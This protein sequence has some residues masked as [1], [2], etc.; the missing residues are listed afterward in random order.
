MDYKKVLNILLR[1]TI[2]IYIVARMFNMYPDTNVISFISLVITLSGMIL[3]DYLTY[4][5]INVP[6]GVTNSSVELL[7]VLNMIFLSYFYAKLC[8]LY[9]LFKN[10]KLWQKHLIFLSITLLVFPVAMFD[11]KI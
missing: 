10:N 5:Q 11:F 1:C 2:Y 7:L 8:G 6:D 3:G 9:K 4:Y